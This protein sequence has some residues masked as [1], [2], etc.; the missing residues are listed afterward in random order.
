MFN[1]GHIYRHI[2]D[3]PQVSR[4]DLAHLTESEDDADE[5]LVDVGT[6]KPMRKEMVFFKSGYVQSMM[7]CVS[8]D[9]FYFC[10]CKCLS[11]FAL[12]KTYNVC[13]S[14]SRKSGFVNGASCN[15][16]ASALGRRN[17]IAALM[18]AILDWT[19]KSK[20]VDLP[21]CTSLLCEWNK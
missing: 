18:F 13:V 11:S 21:A 9:N 17:Q 6:E 12:K 20:T 14:L 5:D 15:C 3:S 1:Y 4:T 8:E 16:K 7:N 2:I 19:Q 10:R